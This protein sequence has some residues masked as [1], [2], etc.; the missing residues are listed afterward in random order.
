MELSSSGLDRNHRRH[1]DAV[2]EQFGR[3]LGGNNV[4]LKSK[5]KEV[6][7]ILSSRRSCGEIVNWIHFTR[8]QADFDLLRQRS[9]GKDGLHVIR[10]A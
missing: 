4:C 7:R 2:A 1:R 3:E 6:R 5:S 8:L 10:H 9:R